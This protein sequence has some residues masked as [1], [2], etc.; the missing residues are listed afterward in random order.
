MI[1]S[2]SRWS[3]AAALTKSVNFTS[4]PS[5]CSRDTRVAAPRIRRFLPLPRYSVGEGRG[6]G[7]FE[8][9]LLDYALL[10]PTPPHPIPLPRS[11]KGEGTKI[12]PLSV[13]RDAGVAT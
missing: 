11:T 4:S 1:C 7:A 13:V 2:S 5:R 12:T 3:T 6:E 10:L 8:V 9:D